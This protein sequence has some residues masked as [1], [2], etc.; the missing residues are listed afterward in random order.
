MQCSSATTTE[1]SES[2]CMKTSFAFHLFQTSSS[3]CLTLSSSFPFIIPPPGDSPIHP[4]PVGPMLFG[5]RQDAAQRCFSYRE[6]LGGPCNV[7]SQQSTFTSTEDLSMQ[8]ASSR[9]AS[10]KQGNRT[11]WSD[12]EVKILI[13][14][15][16]QEYEQRHRGK[17]LDAMWDRI[18]ERV[19]SESVVWRESSKKLP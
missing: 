8:T 13:T 10:T 12:G 17:S 11:R 2:D 7:S 1:K 19:N 5:M 6:M 16:S 3:T 9:Q 18:A 4:R 15:Y 14:V